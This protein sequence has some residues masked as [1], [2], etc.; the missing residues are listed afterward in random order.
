MFA[1]TTKVRACGRVYSFIY[2]SWMAVGY[3]VKVS[4]DAQEY[5]SRNAYL[6]VYN[7]SADEKF[8]SMLRGLILAFPDKAKYIAE[9][10]RLQSL[11]QVETIVMRTLCNMEVVE[12]LMS[13]LKFDKHF[14]H[15]VIYTQAWLRQVV[16]TQGAVSVC[17]AANGDV[18]LMHASGC[19]CLRT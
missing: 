3:A 11:P 9:L 17:V 2:Y 14:R 8:V 1:C 4:Q 12:M 15:S 6:H 7:E 10:H 19:S 16:D 18:L 13:L 5:L